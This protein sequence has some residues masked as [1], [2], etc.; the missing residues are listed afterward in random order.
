MSKA[1]SFSEF[2]DLIKHIKDFHTFNSGSKQ[3][4]KIIKYIRPSFDM[5]T[6]EVFYIRFDT[7]LSEP[8]EFLIINEF[9]DIKMSLYDRCMKWLDGDDTII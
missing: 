2:N 4:G 5:R 6:N 1:M 3:T 7:Y 9:K 8:K